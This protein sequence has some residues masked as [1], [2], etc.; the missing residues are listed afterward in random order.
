MK[1][2]K[3]HTQ[4]IYYLRQLFLI[5]RAPCA[6]RYRSDPK[7]LLLSDLVESEEAEAMAEASAGEFQSSED[8]SSPFTH[9]ILQDL[10]A[11]DFQMAEIDRDENG[12]D[13]THTILALAKLA[14]FHAVS[15]CMKKEKSIDIHER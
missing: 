2:I 14:P 3:L 6:F 11:S 8:G 1:R 12:L 15:Y 10:F 9:L 5:P 13:F 7:L 4:N